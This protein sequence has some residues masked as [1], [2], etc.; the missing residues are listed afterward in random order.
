MFDRK[1]KCFEGSQK[2]VDHGNNSVIPMPC[3]VASHFDETLIYILIGQVMTQLKIKRFAQINYK[4]CFGAS[5][6]K[7]IEDFHSV[8]LVPTMHT[9][10]HIILNQQLFVV[11]LSHRILNR[12]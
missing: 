10:V 12:D 8:K 4:S 2:H 1:Y 7:L 6:V 5:C 3:P 11:I 9:T